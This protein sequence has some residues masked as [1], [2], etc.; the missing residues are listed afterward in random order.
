MLLAAVFVD[1]AKWN[2]SES[3]LGT[4]A[5][6]DTGEMATVNETEMY[7]QGA[8]RRQHQLEI[9][10]TLGEGTHGKV[11]LATDPVSM[12]KVYNWFCIMRNELHVSAKR[13]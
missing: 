4:L 8:L 9:I 2:N 6:N 7:H 10:K 5:M 1:R 11:V 3:C 12:Q 13:K